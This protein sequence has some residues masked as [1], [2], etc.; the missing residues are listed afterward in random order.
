MYRAP[1]VRRGDPGHERVTASLQPLEA[2]NDLT[3][4]SVT[5]DL[6]LLEDRSAVSDNLEPPAT[7][8]HEFD[9]RV[10]KPLLDLGRQPGSPRFVVSDG[11][12]FDGDFHRSAV[13]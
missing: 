13:G 2:S 7:R 5:P 6:R 10:G 4:L 8:R 12:V 3:G 1:G 11:A 9:L